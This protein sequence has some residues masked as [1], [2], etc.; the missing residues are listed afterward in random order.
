MND[1]D[2][3]LFFNDFTTSQTSTSTSSPSTIVSEN[4][5]G[6]GATPP[7]DPI[8]DDITLDL[9]NFDPVNVDT[10]FQKFLEQTSQ[11][12]FY[13]NEPTTF[14]NFLSDSPEQFV[15]ETVPSINTCVKIPSPLP[16]ATP[17]TI[18]IEPLTN[19][20]STIKI[21]ST[22]MPLSTPIV[23]VSLVKIDETMSPSSAKRR[24]SPSP[25]PS[26]KSSSTLTFEQ[27]KL[28]YGNLSDDALRKHLRMIKNRESASLSRKRRK[29]LMENLEVQV[30]HLTEENEKLKRDNSRLE[31]EVKM[32]KLE[33]KLLEQH[34]PT[35][36]R[37]VLLGVVLL[38]FFNVFA[39]KTFLPPSTTTTTTTNPFESI[40]FDPNYPNAVVP[41]R[42]ILSDGR[43]TN[44]IGEFAPSNQY[45]ILQCVAFINK[46]HSKR[47]N[48]DLH[49]L[50]K[51]PLSNVI[52]DQ[53]SLTIPS[54]QQHLSR[55]MALHQQRQAA[56]VSGQL[57]PYKSS[58]AETNFDDFIRTIERKNDTLYLVSF[59][60]DHLILPATIQNQTERP[61][62]SII[63]PA[64]MANLNK[65]IEIPSNHVPMIKIDC[66]VEDTK[67]VFVKRSQIPP[68]YRQD[69]F[70]YYS[71]APSQST[72]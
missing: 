21:I 3:D 15:D 45:P 35:P 59:K 38:V 12:D 58:S 61:K 30:K 47:I 53:K 71:S 66:E 39:L 11:N 42:T 24:R 14:A 13:P 34:R 64:S 54:T 60:R 62:M 17:S 68:S 7:M 10:E 36:N 48:E 6:F 16:I 65:S 31:T 51:D 22:V 50:A 69:L 4:D 67:L 1:I 43:S 70:Q 5:S 32:L 27:L 72:I 2:F 37:V 29:E 23:P 55:K 49:S 20:K 63:L 52:P 18:K 56:K 44:P 33:K 46:T 28:Q 57:Q 26:E 41:S 19:G 8:F 9:N 25:P 40:D